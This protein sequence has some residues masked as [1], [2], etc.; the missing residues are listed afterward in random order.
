MPADLRQAQLN[1]ADRSGACLNAA[2]YCG[3]QVKH[4]TSYGPLAGAAID[5][6]TPEIISAFVA[7][8]R[9][10]EYQVSS[11]NRPYKYSAGSFAL[12]LHGAGW[13]RPRR[14]YRYS[15]VNGGVNGS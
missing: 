8:R 9:D 7:K 10:A 15:P 13:R 4:L 11:I 12:Q 1:R 3:I 5:A 6:I 14:P 2:A